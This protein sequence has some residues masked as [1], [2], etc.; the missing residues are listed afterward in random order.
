MSRSLVRQ[1]R[2]SGFTDAQIARMSVGG[3]PL[4]EAADLRGTAATIVVSP[5]GTVRITVPGPPMGKPRMTQRDKWAKRPVVLRYRAWCDRVRAAVGDCL[6]D[7][8]LVAE[9]NWTAYFEPPKSWSKKRRASAIGTI[10]RSVPDRDNL[11]KAILDCLWRHDSAIGCG[12]LRKLWDW[13]G[14]LEIEVVLDTLP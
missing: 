8:A 9:V 6:P 14:R 2:S 1:A 3:K 4:A 11:D 7:A 12:T 5:N 10:H 13:S